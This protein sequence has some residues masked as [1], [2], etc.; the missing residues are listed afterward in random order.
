MTDEIKEKFKE[1]HKKE[2]EEINNQYEEL[3]KDESI[4]EIM[5]DEIKE[6]LDKL[7]NRKQET[8]MQG[9]RECQQKDIEHPFITKEEYIDKILDYITTLQEENDRLNNI[10]NELEN[11]IEDKRNYY[12]ETDNEYWSINQ[13]LQELKN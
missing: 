7:S 11:Y 12:C 2:I 1:K 8:L 3:M 5:K 4:K 10:I 6:I 13:I 9:I